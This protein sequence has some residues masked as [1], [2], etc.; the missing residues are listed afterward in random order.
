MLAR[1]M[2]S[3]VNLLDLEPEFVAAPSGM[4]AF[5]YAL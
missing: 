2:L 1:F 5:A 4:T 3:A